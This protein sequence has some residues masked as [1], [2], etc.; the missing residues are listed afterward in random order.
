M[1]APFYFGVLM[2]HAQLPE[3]SATATP[4]HKAPVYVTNYTSAFHAVASQNVCCEKDLQENNS[5]VQG[6]TRTPLQLFLAAKVTSD[7]YITK[8]AYK[9][10]QDAYITFVE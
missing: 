2:N 8:H 4:S 6:E 5:Y 3:L 10:S 1:I 9:F 7:C